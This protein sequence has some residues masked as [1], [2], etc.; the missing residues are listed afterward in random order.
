MKQEKTQKG[1]VSDLVVLS[2][3][4]N[5]TFS[6]ADPAPPAT[7]PAAPPADPPPAAPPADPPPAAPPA[8]GDKTFTQDELNTY[9]ATDRRKNKD[10]L[11]KLTSELEATTKKL[12]L[13]V[14]ERTEVD[15]QLEEFRKQTMTSE[16]LAKEANEKSKKKHE[17]ELADVTA[18]RD[19]WKNDYT[20]STILR[21]ITDAAATNEAVSPRQVVAILRPDTRLVEALDDDGKGTGVLEPRVSLN[22]TNDE[23][24]PVTLD[25]TPKEAVLRMKETDEFLNLFKGTGT[26]GLGGS[27]QGAGGSQADAATL[28]RTDP[29][30]YRE[31]RKDGTIKL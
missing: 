14:Q 26:G 6:D 30:K 1:I 4:W 24:Q 31:G 15:S 20:E 12:N 5:P 25:L 8:D 16:E 9:L 3:I 2:R 13:T 7:P 17:T 23:G 18:E 11:T 10:Q 21:S 28:A 29:E 27:Q 22:T 19:K